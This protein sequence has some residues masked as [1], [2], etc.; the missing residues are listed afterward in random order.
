MT[1]L[2]DTAWLDLTDGQLAAK[3]LVEEDERFER[4]SAAFAARVRADVPQPD[5]DNDADKDGGLGSGDW[6]ARWRDQ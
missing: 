6:L 1:K 4:E 3:L 5:E 2:A